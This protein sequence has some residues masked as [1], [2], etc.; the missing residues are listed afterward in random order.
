MGERKQAVVVVALGVIG[1]YVVERLLKT[2]AY[3]RHVVELQA[4]YREKARAVLSA[5]GEEFR[6]W[7]ELHW[8][9]PTGG[10]YVWLKFPPTISTGPDS[11]LMRACLKEGVLYIP[12]EFCHVRPE[13]DV[14]LAHEARLCY[15]V[16]ALDQIREGVRRLL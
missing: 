14:L 2:G 12:G 7:P 3:D 5:L 16:V 10:M 6:E 15:G 1:R 11:P 8:T 13:D 4:V 9:H